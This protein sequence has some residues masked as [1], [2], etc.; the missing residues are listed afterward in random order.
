MVTTGNG[1]TMVTT[2]SGAVTMPFDI[3]ATITTGIMGAIGLITVVSTLA[4]G[5]HTAMGMGTVMVILT[6][7]VMADH[8]L[9]SVSA[10]SR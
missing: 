6:A 3:T 1:G 4:V 7:E 8:S 9:P 5:T 10:F 2:A